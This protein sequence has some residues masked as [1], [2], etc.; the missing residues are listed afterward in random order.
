MLGKRCAAGTTQLPLTTV[1]PRV[2]ARMM[3][4]VRKALRLRPNL[5]VALVQDGAPEMWNLLR[6]ELR[7][8][9]PAPNFLQVIDFYH[10]FQ[11][12]HSALSI[13]EPDERVR[14]A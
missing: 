11:R 3:S 5:S 4:D 6:T 2:Q 14:I 13:L 1:L 7:R 10:L 12:L 9:R 8:M